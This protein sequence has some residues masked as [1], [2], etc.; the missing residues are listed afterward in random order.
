M[1]TDEF[2]GCRGRREYLGS[3]D[4]SP[5]PM[6]TLLWTAEPEANLLRQVMRRSQL[7]TGCGGCEC[8]C[9]MISSKLTA[10]F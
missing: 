1:S 10:V 8:M 7:L 2:Q 6:E 9:L 5:E 4:M 3:V